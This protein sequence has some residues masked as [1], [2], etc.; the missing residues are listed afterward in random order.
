MYTL[1]L[2]TLTS[3]RIC[4]YLTTWTSCRAYICSLPYTFRT[5]CVIY[6][7]C[8][9]TWISCRTCLCSPPYTSRANYV[10]CTFIYCI[11]S[12]YHHIIIT[13]HFQL[14]FS[15]IL[16]SYCAPFAGAIEGQKPD[17][18][19]GAGDLF[20]SSQAPSKSKYTLSNQRLWPTWYGEHDSYRRTF[21]D[22]N[23]ILWTKDLHLIL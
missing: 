9:T 16:G 15:R 20:S 1:Y 8:L 10:I 18:Y 19:Q 14:T 6:L 12:T 11:A 7:H 2:T 22:G 17:F 3:C 13:Y 23:Q 4:L 21:K 5:T